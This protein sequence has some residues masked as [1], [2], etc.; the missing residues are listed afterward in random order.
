M[1]VANGSAILAADLAALTTTQLA[2]LQV[3]NAQL[4]GALALHFHFQNL[5]A[6]T[7]TYA[8]KK[9]LVVPFDFYL[10]ALSVE[11]N[12]HTAA[13][14]TTVTLTE[15][16]GTW[17]TQITGTTGAGNTALARLLYD[18]AKTPPK[19]DF[20]TGSRAFRMFNRG[21]T[22]TLTATTTNTATPSNVHVT[23][24]ARSIYSRG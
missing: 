13:S 10:E 1:T 5:V 16:L 14:T 6:S 3:D 23:L 4:P 18:N 9:I 21:S 22:L 15:P 19:R 11:S 12:N 17:P 7:P 20:A 8:A 2:A 24:V